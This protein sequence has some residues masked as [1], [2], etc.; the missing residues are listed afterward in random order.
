M[1]LS[2]LVI[3]IPLVIITVLL[4]RNA[5]QPDVETVEWEP[6]ASQAARQAPFEVLAPAELPVGWRATRVTWTPEGGTEPT[7]EES[8]RN[9]WR[10]GVLTDQEIYLELVQG[11]KQPKKLVEMVTREGIDDGSSTIEGEPWNRLISPDRR[12]RSLVRTTPRVTTVVTGD[13][14]YQQLES[15]AG[16]LVPVG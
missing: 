10:L 13:T 3:L 15:Y 6:T 8:V 11:D 1:V 9:R 4:T 16:L 2:L 14:S 12:T 7:G 5:D